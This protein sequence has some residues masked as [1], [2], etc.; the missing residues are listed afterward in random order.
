MLGKIRGGG[1]GG[2]SSSFI[3]DAK[4]SQG[5]DVNLDHSLQQNPRSYVNGTSVATTAAA[6]SSLVLSDIV[7][8]SSR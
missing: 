3:G 5:K 7:S 2:S 1:G 6:G 8:K 4:G